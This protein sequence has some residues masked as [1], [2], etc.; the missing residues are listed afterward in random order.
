MGTIQPIIMYNFPT[1]PGL[2]LGYNNA[3]T[4]SPKADSGNKWQVPLGL[5]FGKSFLL[6]NGDGM[7][8]SVGVYDITQEVDLGHAWQLK[9][10]VS[11][12]FN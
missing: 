1:N 5:T 10:G 9:L 2:Y 12:F 8:L 4:Y 7:D 6:G 11:Y 3:I